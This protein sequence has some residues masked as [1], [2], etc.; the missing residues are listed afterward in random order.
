MEKKLFSH[1]LTH[2]FK[3]NNPFG[4]KLNLGFIYFE[5]IL[6]FN[7]SKDLFLLWDETPHPHFNKSKKQVCSSSL[8]SFEDLS[9]PSFQ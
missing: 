2:R 3:I 9:K 5:K 8:G 6:I 1:P 7:K 4:Y